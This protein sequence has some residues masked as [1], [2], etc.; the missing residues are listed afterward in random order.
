MKA[1]CAGCGQ[2]VEFK[3][4]PPAKVFNDPS[5]SIVVSNHEQTAFCL[6]CKTKVALSLQNIQ[7][8]FVARPIAAPSPIVLAPASALPKVQG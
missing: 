5:V 6:T 7:L 8:S 1:L 4:V 3:D 2:S